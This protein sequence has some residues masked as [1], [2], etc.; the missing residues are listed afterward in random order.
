MDKEHMSAAQ[1]VSAVPPPAAKREAD[2]PADWSWVEAR[3][4]T[5]PMLAALQSGVKG[6]R[7]YSLM[8]KVAAPRTL[9][10]AWE[11]VQAAK[12]A[13]G[14]DGMSVRRFAE[15]A[16][17]YLLELSQ[18]LAQ[19]SYRAQPLRRVDI[20]KAA[21]ATRPLGI[22]TVKDRIVQGALKLVIEPIFERE[23][24][25]TSW[26]FRPRRGCKD[27]L[28]EVD[29][30]LKQGRVWVVDADIQACFDS[31]GHARLMQLIER[32]ISDGRVLK[33]VKMLLEQ[34][35]M[36]GL[37]RWT[38][39]GG[40]P[41]GAVISPLLANIFLHGL[42]ECMREHGCAL[43]RYADDF[44]VLCETQQQAQVALEL[45]RSWTQ[46]AGLTLH[47]EKTRA[48][49]CLLPGQG[50]EFLGYRFEAGQR[51]VRNKSLQRLRDS[52][53]AM[54]RR[55]SGES[56]QRMIALLNPVLRGWFAYF[57][58]ANARTFETLDAFVRRRLRSIL[59]K[60]EG[61]SYVYHRSLEVHRR[62]PKNY[63][64]E[65]GLFTMREAWHA[66]S[67]SR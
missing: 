14:M 5:E 56:L 37:K 26:G 16:E 48:G 39:S 65:L 1:A 13:A 62:W 38:P 63:F 59:C 66:A 6:G 40:T 47:P 30:H 8:D 3:V 28:R 58:H 12:G 36:H 49:N 46:S 31:I 42:D 61:R 53:R 41:Q 24:E 29:R 11:R 9:Q 64:A 34:D 21:G 27:A 57:K 25:P 10:A 50:F 52:V 23:F 35:V 60:R 19:G 55:T 4:W 2:S 44:V 15:G 7:W 22:P 17:G 43:V 32:R 54:T 33:L 45:V 18:A 51:H 67:Q 20:P